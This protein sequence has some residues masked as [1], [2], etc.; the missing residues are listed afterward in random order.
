[1]TTVPALTSDINR[2]PVHPTPL[3]DTW[4]S[5]DN[6]TQLDDTTAHNAGGA[7]GVADTGIAAREADRRLVERF[8]DG[9]ERALA[10]MY[11][12]WSALVFT[13]A[14]RSLGDHTE[15]EDVLQKVFLAAWRGR[16]T[17]DPDRSRLPAW[18]VGITKN[19]VTDAH[20]A[21]ARRRRVENV[22]AGFVPLV[23]P[24]DSIAVADQVLMREELDRLEDVPR[25]VIRLA[26][27]EDLTHIQ[28]ADALG[29]P[30]GTVKSHIRRSLNRLKTRLEVHNDAY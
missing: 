5:T 21:K 2:S 27:Y 10:E 22:A 28:I 13:V 20:R 7:S 18:L 17:F 1:M 4:S 24:D 14:V 25:Q 15:A 19:A 26:F 8:Q 29:L 6:V 3:T 30:L 23:Q 11:A 16:H 12:R 9:D